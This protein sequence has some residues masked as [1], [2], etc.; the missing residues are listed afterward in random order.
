LEALSVETTAPPKRRRT[1][2]IF[3]L[4]SLVLL[5]G[6][7]AFALYLWSQVGTQSDGT[8][9]TFVFSG[10]GHAA[11]VSVESAVAADLAA[12]GVEITGS[13]MRTEVRQQVFLRREKIALT[14]VL[15]AGKQPLE[16]AKLGY[17]LFAKDGAELSRGPLRPETVIAAGKT[18]TV[19]IVEPRVHEAARLEIRKLP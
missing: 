1:L 6:I 18:E 19:E 14:F 15:N 17:V 7:G 10:A 12:D 16:T 5:A 13:G 9:V 3:L 4:L 2:R 8:R 11:S